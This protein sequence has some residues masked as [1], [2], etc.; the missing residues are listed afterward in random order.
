M[1]VHADPLDL[2]RRVG[3]RVRRRA[4]ETY[5]RVPRRRGLAALRAVDDEGAAL[6][7]DAIDAAAR[8]RMTAEERHWV[9]RIEHVR[10]QLNG[11]SEQ[12][13]FRISDLTGNDAHRDMV[14]EGT[15]GAIA[16]KKSQPLTWAW[17]LFQLI[18]RFRP[19]ACLE[20]GTALGISAAFQ[21]AAL[22]L[23]DGGRLVTI[24]ALE[25][26]VG[27]AEDVLDHLGL[28]RVEIRAGRFEE[29]LGAVL[30]ELGRVD[31]VFID[32]NHDELATQLYFEA[33]LPFMSERGVLVFDDI[34]WSEGMERAWGV[35]STDDR[36]RLAVDLGRAGVCLPGA[37][38]VAPGGFSIPL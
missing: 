32:G 14:W 18:R 36:L 5:R 13:Q 22:A 20:L 2:S 31:L 30:N 35:I 38:G 17:L 29:H 3:R 24:E 4:E 12:M 23:E 16:L 33:I 15:V 8:M 26:R 9:E 19:Q 37:P 11:S 1:T 27:I 10:A 34:D 6:L 28:D 7:A 25:G 21:G